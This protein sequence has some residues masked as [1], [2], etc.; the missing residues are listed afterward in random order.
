[1]TNGAG[2]PI[3]H[4][5]YDPAGRL[6][7]KTLGN[8]VF[9]TYEYNAAGQVLHLI[10][11]KADATVLSHF[12]YAYDSSGRRISMAANE[13]TWILDRALIF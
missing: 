1:M 10:N 13:G 9:T 7:R 4:Y 6:S 12:D 5:E 11:H 2:G 8:G 3:V